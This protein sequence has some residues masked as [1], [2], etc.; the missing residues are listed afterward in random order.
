A[1]GRPGVRI[2]LAP[3]RLSELPPETPAAGNVDMHPAARAARASIDVVR[4]R[5]EMLERSVFPRIALQSAAGARARGA[6]APG[7][8]G[9]PSGAWP[10]V[11]NWAAGVSV[12]I[13]VSGLFTVKPQQRVEAENEIAERARYDQTI[14]TLQTQQLRA[15]ALL[16]AA[17]A[18]AGNMPALRR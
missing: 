13:P 5:E 9:P 12:I 2:E 3:G 16:S 14:A 11:S 7:S 18:I 6:V 17:S 15:Q 10:R 4:A 8:A 1:I